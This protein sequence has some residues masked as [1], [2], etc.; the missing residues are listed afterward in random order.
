MWQGRIQLLRE[1]GLA[2]VVDATMERWFTKPFRDRSPQTMARIRNM[3]LATNLESYIACLEAIRD[4]DHRPLLAQI[5]TPT[6]VIAG[7]HDPSTTLE[8]GEFIAQHA[9]N[10]RLAV[11]DTAHIANIEQPQVYAETVLGFLLSSSHPPR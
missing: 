10:A 6:L 1:K 5:N 9:P 2:A 11:L 7:R 8:A 3:F 4:M